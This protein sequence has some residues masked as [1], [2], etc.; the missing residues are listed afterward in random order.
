MRAGENLNYSEE[1]LLYP[2]TATTISGN[3]LLRCQYAFRVAAGLALARQVVE[4]FVMQRPVLEYAGYCLLIHQD[5]TQQLV[6]L[7]RHTGK[8]ELKEQKEAFKVGRVRD[9]LLRHDAQLAERFDDLYN[10]SIDFGGHPNPCALVSAIDFNDPSWTNLPFSDERCS[11]S[12]APAPR[13]S[14]FQP[15]PPSTTA[16]TSNAISSQPKPTVRF[17]LRREASRGRP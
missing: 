10:Q 2:K 15:T 3:L 13:R 4:A 1:N 6:F 5:P 9:V 8:K 7:G 12:R 11:A 16:S 17:A 14:F